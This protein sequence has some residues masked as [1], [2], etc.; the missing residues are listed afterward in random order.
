MANK[1]NYSCIEFNGELLNPSF[2]IYLFEIKKGAKRNF[3]IGMTG[4][5][6][7][8]SAR[9][10][11]HRLS[12]HIDLGKRSTQSQFLLAVKGL[13]G[14]TKNEYLTLKEMKSLDIKLHHWA[15]PGFERWDG[16]M[17]I[18]DKEAPRYKEYE[19]KQ[20]RVRNLENKMIKD[21]SGNHLLNK[22][23]G[24]GEDQL[25]N[26]ELIIYNNIEKIIKQK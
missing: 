16:D 18:I 17:K 6:H 9:S 24:K 8:P 3:Y 26:E 21:F 13:F 11:L 15:I 23:M 4:D 20:K 25:T 1:T 19:K 22:T 14:K 5:N 10:I 7:Y 2:S 12:G